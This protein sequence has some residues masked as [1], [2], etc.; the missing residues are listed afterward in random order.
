MRWADN[1]FFSENK[2]LTQFGGGV[3][4][5]MNVC[6]FLSGQ[7]Q[8]YKRVVEVPGNEHGFDV[9]GATAKMNVGE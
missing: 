3:E 1:G 5:Y 2:R 4:L 7:E 9:T 6:N 8:N